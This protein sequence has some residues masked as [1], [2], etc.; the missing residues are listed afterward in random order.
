MAYIQ[1]RITPDGVWHRRQHDNGH[2]ACGL[3]IGAA[4]HSRD[5]ELDDKLCSK[6]HTSH[7][8]QTGEIIKLEHEEQKYPHD[9]DDRF[10]DDPTPPTWEFERQPLIP[11]DD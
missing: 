10:D 1:I 3:E 5:F 4:W 9:D 6:C 7:E 8:R 2:T 11:D